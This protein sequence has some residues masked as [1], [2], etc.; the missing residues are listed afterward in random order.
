MEITEDNNGNFL[1]AGEIPVPNLFFMFCVLFF[2]TGV[3]WL[4]VLR[5]SRSDF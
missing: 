5:K 3:A 1:S 2:I 4:S